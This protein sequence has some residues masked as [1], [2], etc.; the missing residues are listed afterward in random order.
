[1]TIYSCTECPAEWV[2][3]GFEPDAHHCTQTIRNSDPD[4]EGAEVVEVVLVAPR[5]SN[6]HSYHTRACE[7]IE[8]HG[9]EH[10]RA[11]DPETLGGHWSPC[12][13]CTGRDAR[14]NNGE[15]R[16]CPLPDCEETVAEVP[17]HITSEHSGGDV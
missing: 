3:P 12:Q 2:D 1:M 5:N 13:S 4:G 9:R 11:R 10:F 14:G 17:A 16:E 7:I 6:R 15:G 8:R